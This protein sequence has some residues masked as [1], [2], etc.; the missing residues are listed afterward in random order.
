M[1]AFGMTAFD[2]ETE[3]IEDPTIGELK[4][5]FKSWGLVDPE[6]SDSHF[7]PLKYHTCTREE[8]RLEDGPDGEPPIP[9]NF[10]PIK[11]SGTQVDLDYYYKKLKCLDQDQTV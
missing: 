4:P 1:F 6:A 8:L 3:S 5:Y 10:Y 9:S 11:K 7:Q 2:D